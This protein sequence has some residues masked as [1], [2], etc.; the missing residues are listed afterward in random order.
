MWFIL[1]AIC[2]FKIT[3]IFIFIIYCVVTFLLVMYNAQT[4]ELKKCIVPQ[5]TNVE[6]E[7]PI[8]SRDSV[9]D[10]LEILTEKLTEKEHVLQK[11]QCEIKDAEKVL[12]DL[13]NKTSSC[14][15]RYRSL[16]IDLKK[17]IRKTEDE[18]RMLQ[19]QISSLSI[20][21]EALRSEVLKQ[22]EDYQKMLNSFSKELENKKILFSSSI[23]KSRHPRYCFSY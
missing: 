1:F 20:R 5:D 15:D 11:S 16:M 13:E 2:I 18:V 7:F 12:T 23:E 9:D 14:R 8:E 3:C 10:K 22:Q 21:R 4:E 17:D 6:E 19:N